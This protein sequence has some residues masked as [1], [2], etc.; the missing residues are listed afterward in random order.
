MTYVVCYEYNHE[1]LDLP[2]IPNVGWHKDRDTAEQSVQYILSR[3]HTK[4][5][6]WVVLDEDGDDYKAYMIHG[7]RT[8]VLIIGATE[9]EVRHH[10]KKAE[11]YV[12]LWRAKGLIE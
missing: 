5:Q 6:T 8:L 12:P 4:G 2:M 10:S 3:A 7:E 9:E 11:E 1:L